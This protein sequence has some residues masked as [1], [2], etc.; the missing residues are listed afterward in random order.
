MRFQHVLSIAVT[1]GTAR[2]SEVALEA[3]F[4][5]QSHLARD[6]RRLAGAPMG[7]LLSA[8]RPDSPWWPLVTRRSMIDPGDLRLPG[9]SA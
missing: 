6:T 5:D 9:I 2:M 4:Y 8:A 1:A 3:G 7:S